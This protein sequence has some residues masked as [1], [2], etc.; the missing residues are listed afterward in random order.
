MCESCVLRWYHA[1]SCPASDD[2]YSDSTL[3]LMTVAM[4]QCMDI[5]ARL[6]GC[7]VFFLCVFNVC[8]NSH[9]LSMLYLFYTRMFY[10]GLVLMSGDRE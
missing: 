5:G 7:G 2:F 6:H 3:I 1:E 8:L 4:K 10:L 9:G